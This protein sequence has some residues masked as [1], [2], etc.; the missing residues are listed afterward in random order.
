MQIITM[1]IP[2]VR[3]IR[4]I[5]HSDARGF[6]SETY[7]ARD[8]AEHGIDLCFVQDNHSRSEQAWTVRGLHFQRPP[9]AQSKLVRV[10]KG[11]ILDIAVDIRRGS[12]WYGRH[13]D[14]ELD[15]AGGEQVLVPHGFAHGFMTL[16]PDTEVLYKV[17]DYYSREHDAG[18]LWKDENLSI[19]WPV[20]EDQVMISNKDGG[21]PLLRDLPAYFTYG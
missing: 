15:A 11:A 21:L 13:V 12:P 19:A 20:A 4:P 3:L 1:P 16:Q 10:L 9:H 2:D 17:D 7:N 14:V 8:W 6:F 5:R 18:I